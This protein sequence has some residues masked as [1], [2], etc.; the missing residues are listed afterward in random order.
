MGEDARQAQRKIN[1]LDMKRLEIFD[2]GHHK[3]KE[4]LRVLEHQRGECEAQLGDVHRRLQEIEKE[5]KARANAI[6]V[7]WLEGSQ[8]AEE[9]VRSLEAEGIAYINELQAKT[10]QLDEECK[11]E[12]AS[13]QERGFSAVKAFGRQGRRTMDAALP[14]ALAARRPE[15]DAAAASRS[16]LDRLKPIPAQLQAAAD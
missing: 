1:E 3:V 13:A 5:T 7:Q 2:A 8:A 4:S 11:E 15:E 12:H 6:L 14:K 10:M 9:D 16:E